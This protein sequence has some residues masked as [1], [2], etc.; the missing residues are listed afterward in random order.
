MKRRPPLRFRSGLVIILGWDLL[1]ALHNMRLPVQT[2]EIP[3]TDLEALS[4]PCLLLRADGAF[5]LITAHDPA[6][7]L[8]V[9][10]PQDG[11]ET[12]IGASAGLGTL[13]LIGDA[14]RNDL[15][16]SPQTTWELLSGLMPQL[17]PLF[18]ASL[19]I[20]LLGLTTPFLVM[21]IYNTAIPAGSLEFLAALSGGLALA[22]AAELMIRRVRSA[23]IVH[24]A[25]GLENRLGL[26]LLHK[27]VKLPLAT[28]LR[29]DALQQRA[30]LRQF[31]SMRDAM[32]GP[33]VQAVLDI[34]FLVLFAVALFAVSPSIGWMTLAF[35]GL[36]AL[37]FVV[38]GPFQRRRE[39]AAAD[40]QTD[41]RKLVLQSVSAQ[42]AIRQA[43]SQDI[44]QSRLEEVTMIARLAEADLQNF[45]RTA[46][47]LLQSI[48]T[49][50]GLSAGLMAA[51][52]VM[53]GTLSLGALIAILILVWRIMAPV[54]SLSL[55]ADQAISIWAATRTI[56][57][58]LRIPEEKHRGV[59][60]S[61]SAT[62]SGDIRFEQVTFRYPDAHFPALGGASFAARQGEIVILAGP[63]LSGKTT[64]IELLAGLQEPLAGRILINGEDIR[65][66][67]LDDL[68]AGMAVCMQ[69]PSFLHG[70]I[71]QNLEI[72]MSLAD[73]DACWAALD[74]A[75]IAGWVARLPDHI[76][77]L[78]STDAVAAM[79]LS[80][81][82]GIS[83]AM[84]L[85]RPSPIY[86]LDQPTS[87]LD[88]AHA[89]H[90]RN[91]INW[92]R[93]KGTVILTTHDPEDLSLGDRFIVL[94]RG[95]V[96]SNEA[97]KRGLER[98]R[99]LMKPKDAS[100]VA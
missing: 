46:R 51:N 35:V 41:V 36:N 99:A 82:R 59:T 63:M 98:A 4:L 64:A 91:E 95:R 86:V 18:L 90:V 80:L 38:I 72:A 29:S 28:A 57:A 56:D 68:R 17:W 27:L 73:E 43:G 83:L 5:G 6:R 76:E 50:A 44:W 96:I 7:G 26:R 22:Y 87:G 2:A 9:T 15:T 30:R 19:L 16:E 33:L 62:V 20:S 81:K 8:M 37:G 66:I 25:A 47:T 42:R 40:A 52:Q 60:P 88:P 49:I 69:E 13:V 100:K 10:H 58:V 24:V 94:E 92:L 34:P 65:Q 71:R 1:E 48:L 23:A 78:L 21:T 85:I 93:G 3:E 89:A 97:G 61:M 77:T 75:G 39:V 55:V 67:P 14:D 32:L 74:Q 31:E 45:A 84:A 54:Q 70:T 11:T 12:W 53:A 79:P